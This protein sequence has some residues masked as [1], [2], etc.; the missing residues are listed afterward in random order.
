M[1]TVFTL[2]DARNNA[3]TLIMEIGP[4]YC[5][6]AF[7]DTQAKSF[8][9]IRYIVFDEMEAGE[10]LRIVTADQQKNEQLRV[11]TNLADVIITNWTVNQAEVIYLLL[12]GKTQ[13]QMAKELKIVQS[14]VN[15]RIKLAKWKEIEKAIQYIAALIEQS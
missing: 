10:F 8:D 11:I 14:A 12:E 13:Q 4:D 6:Y 9:L 1:K 3:E 7:L 15:N 2:G 5:C